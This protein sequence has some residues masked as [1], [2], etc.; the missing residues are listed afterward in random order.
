MEFI[1]RHYTKCL[2]V[3]LVVA[4]SWSV[5]AS[6]RPKPERVFQGKILASSKR[7]SKVAKSENAFIRKVR[8]QAKK[9]FWE[10]AKSQS[11]RIYYAAFFRTP[12][13]D[14]EITVKLY[15]IT[16]GTKRLRESYQQYLGQRGRGSV[17]SHITL[18]RSKYGVN[19]VIEMVIESKKKVLARG[20]FRVLGKVARG[21]GVVD[22]TEE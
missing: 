19:R 1:C 8:K 5:P 12:L 6:A 11:W 13:N 16:E 21:S 9:T 15:D 10:D 4:W 18:S 3:F 7:F 14:L 17:I 20:K 2:L 22:F